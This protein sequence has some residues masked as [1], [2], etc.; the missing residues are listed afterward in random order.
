MKLGGWATAGLLFIFALIC[1]HTGKL[2][3]VM[4]DVR[5]PI[6]LRDGPHSHTIV[7]FSDLARV[8]LGRG[9]RPHPYHHLLVHTSHTCSSLSGE[10]P[11]N[12]VPILFLASIARTRMFHY[13]L[14]CKLA[15]HALNPKY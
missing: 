10:F 6:R 13:A 3:G 8:A 5:S 7:G 12:H 11:T 15:T 14:G 9:F 2:L 4:M 1:N